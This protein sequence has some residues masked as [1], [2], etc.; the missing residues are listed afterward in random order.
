MQDINDAILAVWNAAENDRSAIPNQILM[1]YD[2]FNY[3]ATTRVSDLAEKTILTFLME[4]NVSKQNGVDLYI[5]A[6][7][8]CK[9]AGAGGTD[10]MII[11]INAER[12]L[13]MDELAPL[14]RAMTQPN[15]TNLCYDTAYLANISETQ[16][17]YENIMRY[18]DG[19]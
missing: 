3:L 9:G 13:A 2:Q 14:N 8:W 18:V 1:P 17:F 5:G 4:N 16:L 7:S 12:F 19:I 11:Y 10:R 15:A 6:T